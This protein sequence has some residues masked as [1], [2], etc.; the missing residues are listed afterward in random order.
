MQEREERRSRDGGRLLVVRSEHLAVTFA[1]LTE[2]ASGHRV[3][4]A[5]LP[6]EPWSRRGRLDDAGKSTEV[7][8]WHAR[9]SAV[10]SDPGRRLALRRGW[11]GCEGRRAGPYR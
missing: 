10:R 4:S 8:S 6:P 3:G 9:H 2:H 7:P 1:Y 5:R 11:P